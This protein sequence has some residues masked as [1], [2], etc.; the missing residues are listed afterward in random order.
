MHATERGEATALEFQGRITTYAQLD[1]RSS[2]GAAALIAAG[3]G[4]GTRIAYLGKNSDRYFELLLAAAKAGLVMVPIGW[5]L[6]LPELTYIL[7]DCLARFLF[8]EPPFA[9]LAMAA[10][11]TSGAVVVSTEDALPNLPGYTDWLSRGEGGDTLF[12]PV[13]LADPFVQLYTSGTTGRPKG[14]VLGQGAAFAMRSARKAAGI[15]WDLWDPGDIS[16]VAMPVAHVSGTGWGL[17]A[18]HSGAKS[19]ILPEFDAGEILRRISCEQVTRIF[20]VPTAIQTLL[21]HPNA[22]TSDF[23]RLRYILYGASPIP[24]TL[25]QQAVTIFGCSFVQLYGMTETFGAV[26]ALP[27]EEHNP[28]GD[29]RMRS[30]GRPM[31]GAEIRIVD[32]ALEPVGPGVVGQLQI[33]SPSSM[34]GY[35]RNLEA[36][37]E[38]LI[39]GWVCTGDAG[40]IDVDGY[41][42]L[43]DRLK[44]M[45]ISGGE[46]VYPTEVENTLSAHPDILEVAVIGVPDSRWGEAVTA[47]VVPSNDKEDVQS[48]LAWARERLASYKV[49][50]HV[51]FQPHLPRN[52]SGK[53]L[54]RVLREPYWADYDRRVN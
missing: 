51:V 37:A 25:L 19:I 27:P 21:R 48:I 23:S 9:T 22:A 8:V 40:Y 42:Y 15:E 39:D 3:L 38:T 41:I 43:H 24:L 2:L 5:R 34:L 50:K 54:R 11:K 29:S 45:I 31:P 13:D 36:T 46:N 18:L 49:P 35:W 12:P 44:D 4:P 14:A 6:T 30:I 28:Q 52:A 1:R 17:D 47:V 16:I 53:V 32:E 7:Q 10:A 26:C 33:R 20:L